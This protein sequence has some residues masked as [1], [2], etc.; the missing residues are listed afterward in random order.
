MT[1]GAAS[2]TIVEKVITMGKTKL[3]E[4]CLTLPCTPLHWNAVAQMHIEI[5]RLLFRFLHCG[6]A[7]LD[8]KLDNVGL[9]QPRHPGSSPAWVICD[10][11]G[12]RDSVE[13]MNLGEAL[14]GMIQRMLNQ[15]KLVLDQYQCDAGRNGWLPCLEA[16]Q[17]LIQNA[18][19]TCTL[20]TD[21]WTRLN[22]IRVQR[23]LFSTKT[24]QAVIQPKMKRFMFFSPCVFILRFPSPTP[25]SLIELEKKVLG[26]GDLLPRPRPSSASSAQG[27][28]WSAPW[29]TTFQNSDPRPSKRQ[30][31]EAVTRD[32]SLEDQ[33]AASS[34]DGKQPTL[35]RV[36]EW[37]NTIC[38]HLLQRSSLLVCNVQEYDLKY[39]AKVLVKCDPI[40]GC[41]HKWN[42][43]FLAAPRELLMLRGEVRAAFCLRHGSGLQDVPAEKS[44]DRFQITQCLHPTGHIAS[45]YWKKIAAEAWTAICREDVTLFLC[46]MHLND[47]QF[48]LMQ[49]S[50]LGLQNQFHV[51]RDQM[52]FFSRPERS[53]LVP[54]QQTHEQ[55]QVDGNLPYEI[56]RGST[57]KKLQRV[58]QMQKGTEQPHVWRVLQDSIADSC[59]IVLFLVFGF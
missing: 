54:Q 4:M 30:K 39:E 10:L 55:R 22:M 8:L 20:A 9:A 16:M 38:I 14:K 56:T 11:N 28:A 58:S 31:D 48:P 23:R 50:L 33:P 6:I 12:L 25:D 47:W 24:I 45:Y 17:T 19:V 52:G 29:P 44:N 32:A 27:T 21:N 35:R 34:P 43:L 2:A 5:L 37:G 41:D 36:N 15:D 18:L 42:L 46:R 40:D 13:C 1:S 3:I 53:H 49:Q 51:S 59:V 7:P 26:L 57:K